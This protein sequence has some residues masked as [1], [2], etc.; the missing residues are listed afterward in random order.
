MN[1]D[2]K[3]PPIKRFDKVEITH[4]TFIG[5]DLKPYKEISIRYSPEDASDY[6]NYL[7]SLGRN[8]NRWTAQQFLRSDIIYHLDL[9]FTEE[10]RIDGQI[11][12]D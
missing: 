9:F 11:N 2:D 8:I 10:V 12:K 6:V 3:F 7:M 4:D 5:D 1:K